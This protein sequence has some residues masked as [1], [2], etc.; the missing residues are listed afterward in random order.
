MTSRFRKCVFVH[1]RFGRKIIFSWA[2]QCMCW[3]CALLQGG[4]T[5]GKCNRCLFH[6]AQSMCE[7]K[8]DLWRCMCV[9]SISSIISIWSFASVVLVYITGFRCVL[10]G[11]TLSQDVHLWSILDLKVGW[12][13]WY[14]TKKLGKKEKHKKRQCS[15]APKYAWILISPQVVSSGMLK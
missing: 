6:V 13:C 15:V 8:L 3:R 5:H 10:C 2:G 14:F 4:V 9:G 1:H 12:C 11:L 7:R